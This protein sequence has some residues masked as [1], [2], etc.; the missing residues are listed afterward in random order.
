MKTDD[1]ELVDGLLPWFVNKTLEPGEHERVRRHLAD[2]E[3]CRS[4][5][6]LWSVVQSTVRHAAA[7]PMVLP[8]RTDRLLEAIDRSG[9][10]SK[11]WRLLAA[12]TLAAA[13][14]AA[15]LAVTLL[16][17]LRENPVPGPA[18]YETATST[19]RQASMDYVLDVEF[20]P[21][22]PV[23]VQGRVL[24]KLAA[25]D[26]SQ[27]E[28]NGTY[29]VTVNLPAAS[30]EELERYMDDVES[31]PHVKSVSAVALQLPVTRPQ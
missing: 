30:L 15:L 20:E 4:N 17:P 1:H 23:A 9:N 5:A 12:G 11:R 25:R 6:S 10:G 27:R 2:C 28:A 8:P 31:L 22:T 7:T 13:S 18:R 14:A 3:A 16:L 26:V 19:P 21:D 29:R 24:N